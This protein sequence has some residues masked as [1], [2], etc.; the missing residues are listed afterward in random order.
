MLLKSVTET[1]LQADKHVGQE[2]SPYAG[3]RPPSIYLS[4]LH[5]ETYSSFFHHSRLFQRESS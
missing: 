4:E 1:R 2:T 3:G 5:S